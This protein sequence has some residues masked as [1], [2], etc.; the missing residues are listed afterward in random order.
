[1]WKK[2]PRFDYI[3]VSDKGQVR[4]IWKEGPR[5]KKQTGALIM[6]QRV[7][8]D[9]YYNVTWTTRKKPTFRL[10]HRM[11][12]ETFVGPCPEGL[13]TRHLDNNKLNNNLNN[14]QWDTYRKNWEDRV[15]L[16]TNA[17]GKAILAPKDIPKIRYM[18]AHGWEHKEIGKRFGVGRTA[19]GDIKHRRTWRD[20]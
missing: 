5:R 16:G 20:F 6:K 13:I 19:I 1:M 11:V 18:L 3:E 15:K 17:V 7:N 12:L 14:I 8:L 10:V 2:Y 9:G 4:R